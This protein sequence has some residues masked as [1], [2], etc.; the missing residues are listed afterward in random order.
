MPVVKQPRCAVP[1]KGTPSSRLNFKPPVREADNLPAT[2]HT[3]EQLTIGALAE[4]TGTTTS[5]IRHYED[6]GLLRTRNDRPA[7]SGDTIWQMWSVCSRSDDAARAMPN[8]KNSIA[9]VDIVVRFLATLRRSGGASMT[10]AR[11]RCTVPTASPR[12]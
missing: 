6:V 11:A 3:S 1:E 9:M 4:R 10:S 2:T 5:T 7:G 8:G 12:R